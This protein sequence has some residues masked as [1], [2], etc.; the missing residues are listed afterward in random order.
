MPNQR[1]TLERQLRIKFLDLNEYPKDAANEMLVV[2]VGA[3]IVYLVWW[4]LYAIC[5]KLGFEKLGTIVHHGVFVVATIFVLGM[6][7]AF[8]V[9]A[10]SVSY[11]AFILDSCVASLFFWLVRGEIRTAWTLTA[12][13]GLAIWGVTQL[14]PVKSKLEEKRRKDADAAACDSN[15]RAPALPTDKG[16]AIRLVAWP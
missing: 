11:G 6:I 8:K 2:G 13:V 7:C 10:A 15:A 1:K 4:L 12:L 14:P 5:F 3:S 9:E 16:Y